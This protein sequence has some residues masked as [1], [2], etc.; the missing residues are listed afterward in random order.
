MEVECEQM[1]KR[2]V[3]SLSLSLHFLSRWETHGKFGSR[4]LRHARESQHVSLQPEKKNKNRP[5]F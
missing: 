3:L 5:I 1:N 4:L 2:R